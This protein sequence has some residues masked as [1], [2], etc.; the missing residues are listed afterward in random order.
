M[1]PSRIPQW[2]LEAGRATLALDGFFG[3]IDLSRT[4]AGLRVV[5]AESSVVVGGLLGVEFPAGFDPGRPHGIDARTRGPDLLAT[6]GA[7][8][9]TP[10]QMDAMWRA[11]PPGANDRFLAAVDLVVSVRTELFDVEPRLVVQSIVAGIEAVRIAADGQS[12]AL[13]PGQDV[14]VRA[15]GAGATCL[16]IRTAIEGLSYAEMVHPADI[17]ESLWR[18]GADQGGSSLVRHGLFCE[19]LERGVILRARMRGVLLPRNGDASVAAA[20]Y[21]AFAAADPPLGA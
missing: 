11:V 7:V 15:P 13:R 3:E 21:A 2:Q 12:R 10:V 20:C 4:E 9:E 6:W 1:P 18:A 19:R 16:L 8:P 17:H 5:L 14:L